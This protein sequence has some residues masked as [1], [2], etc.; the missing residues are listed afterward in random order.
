MKK[1]RRRA[2]MLLTL[3]M[4]L[5]FAVL[6]ASAKEY[7]AA[8]DEDPWMA[9]VMAADDCEVRYTMDGSAE[10]ITATLSAD[11]LPALFRA[12]QNP[13]SNDGTAY[14]N[15]PSRDS[16]QC[17]SGR[18]KNCRVATTN[19]DSDNNLK[20][21]YKYT[22]N[23]EQFSSSETVD[24]GDWSVAVIKSTTGTDLTCRVDVTMTPTRGTDGLSADWLFEA[25]QY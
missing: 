9:A 21:T 25:E 13:Y 1:I 6:P 18:G 2:S 4:V 24:P 5:S 10:I 15:A 22:I 12:N 23:G 7:S 3:A 8:R 16:F 11:E 17:V 20:V 19:M 14:W